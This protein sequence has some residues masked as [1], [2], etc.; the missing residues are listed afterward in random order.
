MFVGIILVIYQPN[1]FQHLCTKFSNLPIC[2]HFY[3][4]KLVF[5][6]QQPYEQCTA[7]LDFQASLSSLNGWWNI[8]QT[9][10]HLITDVFYAIEE[11]STLGGSYLKLG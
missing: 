1:L 4:E 8:P 7:D 11:K 2:K 9:V 10:K 6:L 5:S 3:F